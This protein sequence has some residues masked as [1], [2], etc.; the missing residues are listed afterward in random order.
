[1]PSKI[2]LES[3]RTILEDNGCKCVDCRKC[4]AYKGEGKGCLWD[5]TPFG[6]DVLSAEVSA[7]FEKYLEEAGESPRSAESP[8]KFIAGRWYEYVGPEITCMTCKDFL[9][10]PILCADVD[11]RNGSAS[12]KDSPGITCHAECRDR[13]NFRECGSFVAGT[14]MLNDLQKIAEE[15]IRSL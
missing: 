2:M 5:P 4:P 12:W 10:K 8:E 7:W 1:M 11:K 15:L 13:R 6:G 14:M 9:K 3:A